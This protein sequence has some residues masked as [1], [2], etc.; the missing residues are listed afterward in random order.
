[1]EELPD[2]GLPAWDVAVHLHPRAAHGEELACLHL[3]FHALKQLR[4]ILL[5]PRPLLCLE[6]LGEGRERGTKRQK[7]GRREC[8]VELSKTQVRK[9]WNKKEEKKRITIHEKKVEGEIRV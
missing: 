1:M 9:G 4:I 6:E 2:E 3:Q 8:L 5:A 7:F